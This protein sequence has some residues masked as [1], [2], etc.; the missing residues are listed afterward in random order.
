MRLSRRVLAASRMSDAELT[1]AK[2][3]ELLNR[4][5]IGQ[6]DA[7]KAVATAMRN[8]YRRVLVAQKNYGEPSKTRERLPAKEKRRKRDPCK[9][10]R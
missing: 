8:R 3:V 9:E 2:V 6:M 1:P 4:H 7:K 10:A 5:V